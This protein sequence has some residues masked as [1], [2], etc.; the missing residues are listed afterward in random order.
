MN[1]EPITHAAIL[2]AVETIPE[3]AGPVEA[4]DHIA[5]AIGVEVPAK[6]APWEVAYEAW[7]SDEKGP[8]HTRHVWQAAWEACEKH[9]AIMGQEQQ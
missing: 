4:A 1:A 6:R 5:R 2:A 9:H 3:H 8:R 7:R